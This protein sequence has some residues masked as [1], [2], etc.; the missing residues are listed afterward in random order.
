MPMTVRGYFVLLV[1]A[2][3]L[4][5]LALSAFLVWLNADS[6]RASQEQVHQDY[7]L[8]LTE[9]VDR[10]VRTAIAVLEALRHAALLQQGDIKGFE[11]V[12]RR[13]HSDNPHWLTM[14]LTDTDGQ[15]LMN[16]AAKPDQPLPNIGS[17][18]VIQ[19]VM[20]GKPA[21][22]DLLIGQVT[23]AHLLSMH[24]PVFVEGKQLYALG[25]S[26]RAQHFQRVLERFSVSEGTIAGLVD[27]RGIIIARTLEPEKGMGTPTATMWTQADAAKGILR[28]TDRLQV[29]VVGAFARSELT[30][31]RTIV[32]VRAADFDAPRDKAIL[33]MSLGAAGVLGTGLGI[34]LY[35]GRR[36]VGPLERLAREADRMVAGESIRAGKKSDPVE[37]GELE[38][39]LWLAGQ[40]QREASRSYQESEQRFSLLVHGVCDY[41]IFMLD[42][43]GIVT[44][45]KSWCRADQ[46]LFRRGDNRI[47]LHPFLYRGGPAMQACR[48]RRSPVPRPAA[49]STARAGNSART[50]HASGRRSTLSG[51]WTRKAV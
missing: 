15:Q 47:A 2:V 22:S 37:I 5:A 43:K 21:V 13:V 46:R 29:P 25:I 6:Q 28:G 17:F 33:L 9:V 24:V 42:P 3:V 11:A 23:Q 45:W 44:S 39:A 49:T 27:K 20:R 34:A 40:Q 30:G 8:T 51:F 36:V 32:S 48:N 14:V 7:A 38:H 16:L 31:W 41:A 10:E 18:P 50:E 12:A 35:L 4:P 1:V 26:L 19:E